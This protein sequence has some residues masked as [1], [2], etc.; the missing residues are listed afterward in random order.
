MTEKM[1]KF[2][3]IM[4][5]LQHYQCPEWFRNA[6]FGIYCHWGPQ[7]VPR[8][9]DWY[10]RNMYIQ[11]HRQNKVHLEKYGH[12][13]EFGYKDIIPL[14]KAEKFD[15]DALIKAFKDAGARYTGPVAIHCDHFALWDS[16]IH[17][18]NAAQMGPKR[19]IVG[20]WKD[21]AEKHGL[22]FGC[23]T[24]MSRT[25]SWFQTSHH[26]DKSG[27][28]KGIPYDGENPEYQ[29]LYLSKDSD[30]NGEAPLNPPVS[31]REHWKAC[32]KELIDTY[33]PQFFYYDASVPFQGDDQGQSG[34]EIMAHFYN[35][36]LT[37]TGGKSN[38]FLTI[39]PN[40][41]DTGVVIE[42]ISSMDYERQKLN[43]INPV[44]WQTD[45]SIG[46]WFY[47]NGDRYKTPGRIIRMLIK[48]VSMN[49]NLLLNVPLLPDGTI[50]DE[51]TYILHEIGKWLKTHG[52]AIYNTR[53][54]HTPKERNLYFTQKGTVLYAHVI[55]KATLNIKLKILG[56]NQ[57]T[58]KVKSISL[59]SEN[60]EISFQQTPEALVVDLSNHSL[61]G[62]SN[63]LKIEFE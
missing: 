29:D 41:P 18:W 37:Q 13:S 27:S 28:K 21:A 53:P 44:P 14:W 12:P 60:Q 45:D 3:P 61:N 48:I 49:G 55:K 11:D 26:A 40:F 24:H 25:Y 1:E 35:D 59:L 36:N 22:I 23:T 9:G 38:G 51:S 31:W 56:L 20:L 16:K 4:E 58:Q 43:E 34:M 32:M 42:N 46:D 47:D 50:D 63:V 52:E 33:H 19:D 30:D 7:C 62:L 57:T 39:K 15:P 5:S 10:A 2:Q 6:K 54:W 17:R 8:A